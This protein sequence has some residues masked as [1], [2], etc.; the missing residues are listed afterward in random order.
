[1][2][3]YNHTL[4]QAKEIYRCSVD[5]AY[6]ISKYSMLFSPSEGAISFHM[7]PHQRE[8]VNALRNFHNIAIKHA[9]QTGIDATLLNWILHQSYFREGNK[10]AI[11]VANRRQMQGVV[12]TIKDYHRMI[13]VWLRSNIKKTRANRIELENGSGIFITYEPTEELRAVSFDAIVCIDVYLHKYRQPDALSWIAAQSLKD[14]KDG[15]KL[16]MASPPQSKQFISYYSAAERNDMPSAKAI[17]VPWNAVPGR[18]FG[19]AKKQSDMIGR[20]H[21]EEEYN[22]QWE[23][24][25]EDC[26]DEIQRKTKRGKIHGVVD[27]MNEPYDPKCQTE[28]FIFPRRAPTKGSKVETL[29]GGYSIGAT[30]DEEYFKDREPVQL[31][32]DLASGKD[33]SVEF[34]IEV[35]EVEAKPQQLKAGWTLE[36]PEAIVTDHSDELVEELT[37][38][39]REEI[40]MDLMQKAQKA[41]SKAMKHVD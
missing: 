29:P 13:P 33:E 1:M 39:M 40:R 8:M 9:R 14:I 17:D 24:I 2:S 6:F 34:Q 28:D 12:E 15:G 27:T 10:T 30:T 20:Y 5:P 36:P 26:A 23:E 4:E 35:K 41:F 22:C 32:L 18:D 37:L 7:Y 16:V 21:F 25:L 31:G 19:W 3:D 11:I 38:A